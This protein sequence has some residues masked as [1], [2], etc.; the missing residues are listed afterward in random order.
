MCTATGTASS[1]IKIRSGGDCSI[2][3][4]GCCS[5]RLNAELENLSRMYC[6]KIGRFSSVGGHGKAIGVVGGIVRL[7]HRHGESFGPGTPVFEQG[8]DLDSPTEH[9]PAV[10]GAASHDATVGKLAGTS[11]RS[12]HALNERYGTLTC[13]D[14]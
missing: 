5:Q 13:L 4:S 6:F 11:P 7:G 12:M 8:F 3:G 2:K 14:T 1:L 9:K 10:V